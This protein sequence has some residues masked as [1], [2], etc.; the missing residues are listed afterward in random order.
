MFSSRILSKDI[1]QF[2]FYWPTIVTIMN[3][4]LMYFL[5][6]IVP[7]AGG[8]NSLLHSIAEKGRFFSKEYTDVLK[9]LCCLVVIYVHIKPERGNA[10]QD[11]IGSFAYVAVTFFFLVSAYGMLAGLERK[12]NYLKN[13]WRN[14]LVSLLIPCLLVNI[15]G[16]L[17]GIVIK[18]HSEFSIL[19]SINSY[20]VVLL[21]WCIWYYVVEM[22][23]IK[24]FTE[25]R[26]LADWILMLGVIIS[27]L[28]LYFFMDAEVSAEAGWCFER[29]GL[30]WGILLYRYY[31]KVVAWMQ[32][33][34][35]TKVIVLTIIGGI[36]GVSYLKF[37]IV[38]FW[39][40][41]LLKIVLGFTLLFLLFSATSNRKFGDTISNWLGSISYEVYLSHGMV[42]GFMSLM[43][44]VGVNSG[45]FIFLAV[46]MILLLSTGIHAVDKPFVK[47]LRKK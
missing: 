34:R 18:G 40:A 10:L 3:T 30:V 1:N 36:L 23:R 25:R 22:C 20:V 28:V 38:Y 6:A 5:T 17:L 43:L 47:W 27:S 16:Y 19:Y 2:C 4:L 14:R 42:L 7:L 39:G 12:E 46:I 29:M 41:Y 26:M 24:W 31:D 9:G 8:G 44:P 21:Q 15:V 13:F 33:F 45:V 11:A 35:V 32:A 37:K